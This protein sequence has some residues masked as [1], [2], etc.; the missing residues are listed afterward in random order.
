MFERKTKKQMYEAGDF[1]I[2]TYINSETAIK[3][4]YYLRNGLLHVRYTVDRCVELSP[5][6]AEM[7]KEKIADKPFD[8]QAIL[9][10]GWSFFTK[11]VKK[12]IIQDGIQ[13]FE[14]RLKDLQNGLKN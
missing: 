12:T 4:Y 5:S 14:K 8:K 10:E 3:P 13:E 7:L 1:S 6:E 9:S 2:R 11:C